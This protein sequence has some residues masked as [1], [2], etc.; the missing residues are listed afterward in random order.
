MHI[1]IEDD[2]IY[3]YDGQ[4]YR[5]IISSKISSNE[6]KQKNNV[7]YPIRKMR[8]NSSFCSFESVELSNLEVVHYPNEKECKNI[9]NSFANDYPI[10]LNNIMNNSEQFNQVEEICFSDGEE[11]TTGETIIQ[12]LAF[13]LISSYLKE[14]GIKINMNFDITE[15]KQAKYVRI[16]LKNCEDI[17][18]EVLDEHKINYK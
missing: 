15:I 7:I 18:C 10:L 12:A 17:Y 1:L 13:R 14:K 5:K 11:L 3:W 8:N 16:K 6:L 9:I 4:N 2:C